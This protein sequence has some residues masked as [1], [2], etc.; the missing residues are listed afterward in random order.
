MIR[1]GS[2]RKGLRRRRGSDGWE[3]EEDIPLFSPTTKE[4]P[5][6]LDPATSGIVKEIARI[7][8]KPSELVPAPTRPSQDREAAWGDKTPVR[9]LRKVWLSFI[10]AIVVMFLAIGWAN[11]QGRESDGTQSGIPGGFVVIEE[12]EDTESPLYAFLQNSYQKQQQALRIFRQFTA[13]KKPAHIMP[14]IRMT[15][16]TPSMLEKFWQPWPSPPLLDQSDQITYEFEEAENRAFL[17]MVGKNQDGSSF[18]AFF[19]EV[20]GNLVLDWEAT[21][22][23]GDA[24]LATLARHPTDHP[25]KMRVILSPSPYYLPSLPESEY[26]S[27]QITSLRDDTIV[28]GYVRRDSPTHV[29]IRGAMQLDLALLDQMNE[30]RVTIK[31]QKTDD[32]TS[33]NRFFITEMLHKDWVMP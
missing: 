18:T 5:I 27:Y 11:R 10:G 22:E 24:R 13:A 4:E 14:L 25:V 19:V 28:W 30:V 21:L 23:V 29:K 1:K 2:S 9:D 31:M 8:A 6:K 16:T 33:Q 3:L 15:D 32:I 26:E 20:D 12:G 17:R 7:H